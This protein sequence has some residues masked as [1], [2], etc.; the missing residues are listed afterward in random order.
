MENYKRVTRWLTPFGGEGESQ[1]NEAKAEDHIPG[2]DV[3]DG[4]ACR[5]DV[6]NNDPD[7]AG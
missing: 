6:E 3:W 2:A 7:Q 5:G 4:I 1:P